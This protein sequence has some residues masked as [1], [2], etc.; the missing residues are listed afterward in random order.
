MTT[1]T[2]YKVLDQRGVK[3]L[4]Y[5]RL[6]KF[7]FLKWYE[8]EFIPYPNNKGKPQVVCNKIQKY[9]NLKKFCMEYSNIEEYFKGEYNERKAKFKKNKY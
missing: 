8:W 7:W 5:L 2:P 6:Y 9:S 1:V 4:Q 3:Y